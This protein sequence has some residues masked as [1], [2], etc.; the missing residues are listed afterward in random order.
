MR[1]LTLDLPP[2]VSLGP[3]DFFVSDANARAYA[4]IL[5]PDSW[6]EAKLALIGPAGCGKSHL[7]RVFV[8]LHGGS[9][10][11]AADLTAQTPL[12]DGPLVL[13]DLHDLPPQAEE[14]VFHLHNHLKSRRLPFL[15]TADV[16]PSRWSITLP[17][18][19]SRVQAATIAQI[20]D[21]DDLLLQAVIM[22][23]F[24]DRQLKAAPKLI[25]YL[26]SRIE[27]SFAAAADVVAR[28]DAAALATGA[29]LGL[30][31]AR[32]VLDVTGPDSA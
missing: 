7:A 11:R 24:A 31:L 20:D 9:L 22:K 19:A 4:M 6:P 10:L 25:A 8:H 18:L 29:P 28:M 13:E 2:R 23:H 30:G 16:A 14:I 27:R 12:P 3:D 1:Q 5:A 17:D 15:M 26:S 32:Q 21:P